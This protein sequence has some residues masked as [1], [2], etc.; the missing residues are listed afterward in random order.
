VTSTAAC[1][2]GKVLLGGGGEVTTDDNQQARAVMQSSYP[3]STS[4]WTAVGVVSDS[5]LGGGKTLTVTA[6]ALCSL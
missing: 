2:S 6:Y 5:N 1:A 3:S 4:T